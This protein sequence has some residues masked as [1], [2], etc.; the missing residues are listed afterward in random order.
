MDET[1]TTA[2]L[3]GTRDMLAEQSNALTATVSRDDIEGAL[4]SE[5]PDY[6]IL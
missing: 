3:V 2:M 1:S 4:A 6:L 5:P